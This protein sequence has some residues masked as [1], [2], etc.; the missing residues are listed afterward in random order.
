MRN[1]KPSPVVSLSLSHPN[2]EDI[3]DES[4]S[5]RPLSKMRLIDSHFGLD[6]ECEFEKNMFNFGDF[7]DLPPSD[8][9]TDMRCKN[10]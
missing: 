2:Y 8:R 4:F 9:A 6:D 3:T 5:I 1:N 7:D 10:T